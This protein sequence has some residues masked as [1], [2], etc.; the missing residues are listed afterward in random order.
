[1]DD[2]AARADPAAR[3]AEL[4]AE[5]ARLR[6]RLVRLE[7]EREALLRRAI[8]RDYEPPPHYR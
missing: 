3:I 2:A 5:V 6:A 4:E 8:E 7:A 1:M